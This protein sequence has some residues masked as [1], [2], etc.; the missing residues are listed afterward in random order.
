M[1][2][3]IRNAI[4]LLGGAVLVAA[5]ALILGLLTTSSQSG[6]AQSAVTTGPSNNSPS[7][8]ASVN[9]RPYPNLDAQSVAQLTRNWQVFEN[10]QF[11]FRIKYPPNF[12]TQEWPVEKDVL[13]YVSFIDKKWKNSPSG[14][15]PE[16]GLAIYRNPQSIGLQE[17]FQVHSGT[18]TPQGLPDGVI[19]VDP[20]QVQP[21][22]V[23]GKDALRFVDGGMISLPSILI[24]RGLQIF[25]MA[26]TPAADNLEPAYELMLSTLEFTG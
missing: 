3:I 7:Q 24:N 12:Y 25:R 17:W 4:L 11:G 22:S 14:G 20:T 21:V 13:Y 1:L 10:Q 6:A 26:F 9:P 18:F 2:R 19:F 8:S 5:L 15:L 23:Q 16:I